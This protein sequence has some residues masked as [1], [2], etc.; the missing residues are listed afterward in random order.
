MVEALGWAAFVLG[1]VGT[2]VLMAERGYRDGMKVAWFAATLAVPGWLTVSFRSIAVDAITG[3]TLATL[4]A[5]LRQPFAGSRTRWVLCDVLVGAFVLTC[6]LSDAVNRI[7]IPGTVI[8]LVRTWVLPYLVGR[9]FLHFWDEMRGV[10][11]VLVALVAGISV[12]A[13]FE[14]VSHINILAV[15]TGKKWDLLETAEGFR[16][17]LKRAQG[18][19]NHPI[20][21]GLL[22]ALTLPWSLMAARAAMRHEAPRWWVAV[23]ALVAAAA[24]VTVSRAAH[25]AILIVFTADLFFRRP[26]YRIPMLF[27]AVAIGL[28]FFVFREEALDLLGAY[29][30]ETTAGVERVKI[31]GVEYDYTGTRHRDLLLLAYDEAIEQAGW[32]GYGTTFQDMPLD[33]NMDVRF[34]SIDHHY[35][36]H[37]LRY[38][39]LGT[40][41]F[42]ALAAAGAWNLGREALARDGPLSDLAAGLFGAFVAVVL[43]VRGVAFS[44]DFGATW[45]F[46]AGLAASWRARRLVAATIAK[47]TDSSERSNDAGG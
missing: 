5:T 1:F 10:L 35:L 8:E 26:S 30:G 29:A 36:F 42:L 45:L 46:V 4:I 31:Y 18:N 19:T 3:V 23:P 17:G 15:L 24:F 13:L 27:V 33:P 28:V 39:I 12:Y 25:L 44:F 16:W 7:L 9:L 40:A 20:Y 37:Y 11:P 38:G 47:A 14:A 43:L 22:L 34:W 2:L 41:A 6:V 21:F 32:F